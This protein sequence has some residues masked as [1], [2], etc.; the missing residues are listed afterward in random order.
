MLESNSVNEFI[1][2]LNKSFDSSILS[3]NNPNFLKIQKP[4]FNS[5][6]KVKFMKKNDIENGNCQTDTESQSTVTEGG[7]KGKNLLFELLQT[8]R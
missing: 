6:T 8:I 4:K 2:S 3:I 5:A 7:E 1:I